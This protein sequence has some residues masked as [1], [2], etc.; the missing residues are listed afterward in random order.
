M[1]KLFKLLVWA[2]AISI[3]VYLAALPKLRSSQGKST[4]RAQAGTSAMAV[5]IHQVSGATLDNKITSTGTVLANEEV[6]LQP[7]V[8][9]RVTGIH[10]NEGTLVR[11]GTLLVKLDDRDLQAELSK[12]I[13]QIKLAEEQEKRQNTLLKKGGA[14]QAEYDI[15]LNELNVLKAEEALL[16]AR[17]SRTEVRAP[18]SGIIGLRNISTGTFVSSATN[19]AGLQDVSKLKIE[20]SI[21]GKYAMYV[22]KGQKVRYTIPGVKEDFPAEIY[23]IDPK[24]DPDSRTIMV[25]ALSTQHQKTVFP[26]AFAEVELVLDQIENGILVPSEAIVPDIR[27]HKVY[28]YKSGKVE[29]APVEI[30]FRKE[31]MTYLA[32]GVNPGDTVITSGMIQ[33]RPGMDV[34]VK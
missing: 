4:K 17:I 25:R 34:L 9:G 15:A 13:H 14:S 29:V 7:E 23:A 1:K 26:G 3:V 28:L 6:T 31:Q 21:P 32:K 2:A 11:K 18:F 8:S 27:G 5:N 33:L 24:I 10:F 12:V 16:R 22:R 19:I 30:G 20:F